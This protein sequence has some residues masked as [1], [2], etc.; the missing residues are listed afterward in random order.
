[1]SSKSNKLSSA[2]IATF[3]AKRD[4]GAEMLQSIRDMKAGNCKVV[5]SLATAAR[6]AQRRGAHFA[7]NRQ[8]QSQG[9]VGRGGEVMR[10]RLSTLPMAAPPDGGPRKMRDLSQY[11]HAMCVVH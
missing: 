4:L 6:A 7:G 2:E 8:H 10:R 3:E 5:V 9:G 11:S 1:M